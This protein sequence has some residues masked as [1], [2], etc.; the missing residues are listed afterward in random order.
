MYTNEEQCMLRNLLEEVPEEE[1]TERGFESD[2]WSDHE[3]ESEHFSASEDDAEPES[4]ANSSDGHQ[5]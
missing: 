2:L 4:T 3:S 1:V 5:V